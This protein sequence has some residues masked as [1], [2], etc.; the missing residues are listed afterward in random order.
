MKKIVIFIAALALPFMLLSQENKFEYTPKVKNRIEVVNLIGKI[1]LKNASGGAIVIESDF[2]LE[3]PERA[4]GLQLLGSTE[5]N[6]EMGINV[7]EKDGVVT[8]SGVTKKVQDYAYTI[9]VPEGMAINIDYHNPF[10]NDDMHIDSYNGSVEVK[11][12]TAN[13]KIS[14]C[15]GPFTVSSVSGDIEAT[16]SSLNQD[17]PTSL[18]SVS[19]LVDV[20]LATNTKATI[21]VKNITG[22]VY[23]N[24]DLVSNSA[25]GEDERSDGLEA[26][27]SKAESEYTL[28]GGG[29]KLVVNSISGNIYLRK[30]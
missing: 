30:K 26:I 5:D 2:N 8:I 29:Q 28:N 4:E 21:E 27:G 20:S 15:T 12:L 19:G 25:K 14:N 17:Q 18:A 3:K 23:N 24:L 22:D 16:F 6:T 13:V 10:A 1:E 9:S 11:T 7:T